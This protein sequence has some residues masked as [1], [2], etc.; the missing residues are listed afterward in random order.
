MRIDDRALPLPST[1]PSKKDGVSFEK[2]NLKLPNGT[3]IS[4]EIAKTTAQRE[5]GLMFRES[6]SNSYGMLFVFP[7]QRFLTFWM[8]NTFVEL[9]MVFLNDERR[10]TGIHARVPK[11]GKNMSDA[12]VAR[13]SGVGRYVL[14]LPG[15]SAQGYGLAAGQR[16]H[17]TVP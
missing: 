1:S 9:D 2:T 16:L 4:V 12:R 14:E 8:K 7:N 13:R 17:F 15:G 5:K 10:I 11:S 6:L 3:V